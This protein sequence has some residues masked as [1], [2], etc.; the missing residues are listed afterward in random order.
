VY[1]SVGV[2][3]DPGRAWALPEDVHGDG[4]RAA[5]AEDLEDGRQGQPVGHETAAGADW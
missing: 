4:P 3:T 1:F 2:R 5:A